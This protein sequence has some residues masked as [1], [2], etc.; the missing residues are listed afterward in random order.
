[1]FLPRIREYADVRACLCQRAHKTHYVSTQI[2]LEREALQLSSAACYD[3][4]QD[5][6]VLD[7]V[8]LQFNAPSNPV[9][10]Q[11]RCAGSKLFSPM[12]DTYMGQWILTII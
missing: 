3:N 10:T 8:Q 9:H 2:F 11:S 4:I 5:G 12:K 1:M 7:I 6:I